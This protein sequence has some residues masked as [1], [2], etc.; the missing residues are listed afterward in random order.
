MDTLDK[1]KI[2]STDSQYDLACACGTT[3][4]EH[5]YRGAD[6]KW[7]YPVSMPNGGTSIL[8]KTLLSNS[9]ANDCKYCPLRRDSN[10]RRCSL[11]PDE[12]ARAFMH[13]L[14][15]RNIY[16]LF[17]SS[18][19]TGSSDQTMERLNAVAS[20][21]RRTHRFKGYIHL[22]I[23]PGA[24]DAAIREAV[25]LA[26]AISLNIETPGAA[27]FRKLSGRKLFMEDIIRPLKLMARLTARGEPYARVKT[28]TQFVVGASDETDSEIV[29]YMF[30]L[31]DRLHM[32]RIYFSAYQAGLGAPDIPGELSGAPAPA[33]R[34]MREHRLYQVDFLVRKYGFKADDFIFDARH[35]LDLNK[36]PKECWAERH[37]DFYP[38][39]VN[40]ADRETLLRVPGFGPLTVSRILGQ[41]PQGRLS[42]LQSLNLRRNCMQKALSFIRFD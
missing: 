13:Y 6:G 38:V 31:Y 19:V 5:R 28:T 12:T 37:P 22:K 2:L 29:R 41:R 8:L 23:I 9:C 3:D 25:S 35:N 39:N 16:G 15:H 33:E 36:D 24:S 30:G 18:G 21:L 11:S 10:I 20:I 32:R 4:Q 34:L 14:M 7:L 26:S 17:L 1:L 27:H 42:S 40:R